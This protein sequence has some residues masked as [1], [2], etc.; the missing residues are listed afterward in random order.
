M[1]ITDL[2]TFIVFRVLISALVRQT[3]RSSKDSNRSS[4]TSRD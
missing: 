1:E 2:N 3:Q 4:K